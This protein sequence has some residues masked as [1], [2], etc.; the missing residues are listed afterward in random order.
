MPIL[1]YIWGKQLL[2][3]QIVGAC[4]AVFGVFALELG[5]E[6]TTITDGDVMSLVQPLVFGLGFWKMEA[7]MD[8]YPTEAGRL[9][10]AQLLTVFLVSL[11]YL[12]CLSPMVAGGVDV[13]NVVPNASEIIAWLH[14]PY[15]MGMFIWT[16]IIT[17]AFT[18]YMETLA[19]KTLSAA[20]TT[21]IFSTEPLFGAAF[22]AFVAHEYFGL[23]DVIGAAFIIAGCLVSG[24]DVGKVLGGSQKLESPAEEKK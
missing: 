13:C 5:G 21:L 23:H 14:D 11:S 20:E 24:M 15:I 18:I 10:A 6:Q 4:I 1:D 3:R 16:G 12:I 9:A 8:K 2:R 7:A 22:A 19:L 17:T